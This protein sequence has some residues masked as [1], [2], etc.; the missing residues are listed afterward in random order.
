MK[1]NKILCFILAFTLF[2]LTACKGGDVS[3]INSEESE[4]V[5]SS[6]DSSDDFFDGAVDEI[7]EESLG[8]NVSVSS[9]V[10][11][12][13]SSQNVSSEKPKIDYVNHDFKYLSNFYSKI[14]TKD[15]VTV[16]F[17]GGSVT[18]GYGASKASEKG[19][20][21]LV[22]KSLQAK[23]GTN[24]D[25]RKKSIGG[26]GSYLGAF[27]YTTDTAPSVYTQPDLLFIEYAINDHYNYQDEYK[28]GNDESATAVYNKVVKYSESIVRKAYQMNPEVDI[29]YLLTFDRS[30]KDS[31]YIEL[32][33]HMDVAEKYGL[34]CIK[35]AD[36]F[37]K[38][39]SSPSDDVDYI[40]D[41]VHPNDE[42]YAI[43]ADM[44]IEN[45]Y[46]DFPCT[47]VAEPKIVEKT[48]PTAMSDY[49]KNP[50]LI[51][52]NQIDL[53][54]SVGWEFTKTKFSWIGT[55]FGGLVKAT[56]AG[57]KLTVEFEGNHFGLLINR[58]SD[59]GKISV[60][61]DGGEAVIVDAYRSSTNPYAL[62]IADGL[63]DGKHKAEITLIDKTFE[64]DGLLIN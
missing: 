35:L 53:S 48:L 45:L 13:V 44:V 18:D 43:Y 23:F 26:T 4:T 3:E 19:W 21:E 37:Y 57:S 54:N 34:M 56:E 17:I 62:P 47:G 42:G 8:S 11:K 5:S 27:K 33:A 15:Y 40:P 10:S 22:C 9:G 32:K 60:S 58:A 50:T 28:N 7:P 59:M 12:P 52:S 46:S 51:Y 31:N 1:I 64:I 39:L 2:L 6:V 24:V 25:M 55:R 38:K 16:T 61:V 14:T 63:Q 29:V 49:Y 20:P 36:G 41:G 30:T